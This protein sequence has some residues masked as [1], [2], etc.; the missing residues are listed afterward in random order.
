MTAAN[1]A[2]WP[3]LGA[4]A[5]LLDAGRVLLVQ[6]SKDPDA[7]LWGFPGGHV[8]A[9][10]TALDAALRE[11]R[12]ETGVQARARGYLT[13]LDIIRHDA[14]GQLQYHF[15]LAAVLCDYLG[16]DPVA[17]DDA[18]DAAWVPLDQISA[19][20]TSA[21]VARIIA[22]AQGYSTTATIGPI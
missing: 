19:Y 13:N 22:L 5:V 20:P 18:A 8:M 10:E 15:L 9:G 2:P 1:P 6:R 3:K 12:E 21:N 14:A 4:I 11:L 17:G 7:G 16:G